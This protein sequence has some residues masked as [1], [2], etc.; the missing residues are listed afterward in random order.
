MDLAVETA[1][2]QKPTP[3]ARRPTDY[4]KIQFETLVRQFETRNIEVP[5]EYKKTFPQTDEE[6]K[7]NIVAFLQAAFENKRGIQF[8]IRPTQYV[9]NLKNAFKRLFKGK[10]ILSVIK[11]KRRILKNR[12]STGRVKVPQPRLPTPVGEDPGLVQGSRDQNLSRRGERQVRNLRGKGGGQIQIPRVEGDVQIESPRDEGVSELQSHLNEANKRIAQLRQELTIA[13][14][15]K[16]DDSAAANKALERAQAAEENLASAEA[17]IQQ[18]EGRNEAIEKEKASIRDELHAARD[19]LSRSEY[20][21]AA[22]EREL[23]AST[24][25]AN[26][27]RATLNALQVKGDVK[28][29]IDT[30]VDEVKQSHAAALAQYDADQQQLRKELTGHKEENARLR[31]VIS[32]LEGQLLQKDSELQIAKAEVESLIGQVEQ[33]GRKFRS[34]NEELTIARSDLTQAGNDLTAL[35]EEQETLQ[36]DFNISQANLK[37]AK[38]HYSI[39]QVKS[40]NLA[41]Q[42]ARKDFEIKGLRVEIARLRTKVA[43]TEQERAQAAEAERIA[44][45]DAKAAEEAAAK[46]EA[47]RIEREEAESAAKA[48]AQAEAERKAKRVAREEAEALAKAEA[49]RIAR[50]EAEAAAKAEAERIAREEAEAAE[51]AEALAATQAYKD[52]KANAERSSKLEYFT[53]PEGYEWGDFKLVRDENPKFIKVSKGTPDNTFVVN[54]T[55]VAL[56]HAPISE[57]SVNVRDIKRADPITYFS[58]PIKQVNFEEGYFSEN[59]IKWNVDKHGNIEVLQGTSDGILKP[60][61]IITQINGQETT[62]DTDLQ[63]IINAK[64]MIVHQAP[65]ID[66][67]WQETEKEVLEAKNAAERERIRKLKRQAVK[68][69]HKLAAQP[70]QEPSSPQASASKSD[71]VKPYEGYSAPFTVPN[72][73]YN[74]TNFGVNPFKDA[75]HEFVLQVT[76]ND[77]ETELQPGDVIIQV[78]GDVPVNDWNSLENA[79]EFTVI[80]PDRQASTPTKI[81]SPPRRQELDPYVFASQNVTGQNTTLLHGYLPANLPTNL[82][83]KIADDLLRVSKILNP[84]LIKGLQVGDIVWTVNGGNQGSPETLLEAIQNLS[85]PR[86]IKL[87]RYNSASQ[88]QGSPPQA[89]PRPPVT[90]TVSKE[91]QGSPPQA[92]SPEQE[93]SDM[94][95]TTSFS[96]ESQGVTFA[97]S[98]STPKSDNPESPSSKGQSQ[99]PQ[100][101]PATEDLKSEPSTPSSQG[102]TETP[103]ASPSQGGTVTSLSPA[104]T[105]EYPLD[106]LNQ[107]S[108]NIDEQIRGFYFMHPMAS[109]NLKNYFKQGDKADIDRLVSIARFLPENLQVLLRDGILI[110]SKSSIIPLEIMVET[111]LEEFPKEPAMG[112]FLGNTS[113]EMVVYRSY[114]VLIMTYL[115]T[116]DNLNM[117]SFERSP[118]SLKSHENVQ[119]EDTWTNE[120]APLD[121]LLEL[122][123]LSK[124]RNLTM[125]VLPRYTQ[126]FDQSQG[127][128]RVKQR[129]EDAWT[130]VT[131]HI[132]QQKQKRETGIALSK[133]Y[134]QHLKDILQL[135]EGLLTEDQFYQFCLSSYANVYF[136]RKQSPVVQKRD[137]IQRKIQKFLEIMNSAGRNNRIQLNIGKNVQYTYGTTEGKFKVQGIRNHYP[138]LTSGLVYM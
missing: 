8:L 16:V 84:D 46:A 65:I 94:Y 48:K 30:A 93:E 81:A 9:K 14:A 76:R 35:R 114:E 47:E 97:G 133:F 108:K 26:Q 95:K 40:S 122:F 68:R 32:D 104:G 75:V 27:L 7:I 60:F 17:T 135:K 87:K 138:A 4:L 77:L 12:L 102:G 89:S 50:E 62:T 71:V 109:T 34:V 91:S 55:I 18:L 72:K 54:D 41:L 39:E 3:R 11:E 90:T 113:E 118:I 67:D 80:R 136:A 128:P 96:D 25:D 28:E 1:L 15:Q 92:S 121:T 120:K 37:D 73:G 110:R 56:N 49:E 53:A 99:Q 6:N 98:S 36:K 111:M 70:Q 126:F 10:E 51:K 116:L 107:I 79:N 42:D 52:A 29:Q 33:Q 45:R 23:R 115:N 125:D 127:K 19:S 100:Y 69:G 61:D 13:V 24:T 5:N 103:Q 58:A 74:Q 63:D 134:C 20:T 131:D 57:E 101:L 78:D 137:Q 105:K 123:S 64:Y 112:F 119:P 82:E 85:E 88:N 43:N 86:T 38:R 130:F 129:Y 132:N 31:D 83:F 21:V 117:E 59:P 106:I 22:K 2:P 66:P 44:R 124:R